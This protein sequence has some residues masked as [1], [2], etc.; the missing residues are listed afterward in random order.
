ME[1]EGKISTVSGLILL[2]FT[3]PVFLI[4]FLP[5]LFPS[6]TVESQLYNSCLCLQDTFTQYLNCEWKSSSQ[7]ILVEVTVF[8]Q[9]FL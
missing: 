4:S 9:L 1:Y 3:I 2:H 5:S 6:G 7:F 8:N